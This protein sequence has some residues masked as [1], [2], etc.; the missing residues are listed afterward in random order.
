VGE[1]LEGELGWPADMTNSF[2]LF[3]LPVFVSFLSLSL[4][5][6]SVCLSLVGGW[7]GVSRTASAASTLRAR[8]MSWAESGSLNPPWAHLVAKASAGGKEGGREGGRE[9]LNE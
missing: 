3:P 7:V 4:S 8:A 9:G 6:L 5:C 2:S 1:W